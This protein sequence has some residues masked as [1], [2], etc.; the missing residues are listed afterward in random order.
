MAVGGLSHRLSIATIKSPTGP[1]LFST[2]NHAL[3]G[4]SE[5]KQT[6]RREEENSVCG[7]ETLR[8]VKLTSARPERTFAETL[9][10]WLKGGEWVLKTTA[11]PVLGPYINLPWLPAHQPPRQNEREIWRWAACHVVCP[12]PQS[13]LRLDLG[14]SRLWTKRWLG[15]LTSLIQL[16]E[17]EKR[18]RQVR[19]WC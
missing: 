19:V 7:A 18:E 11:N 10:H 3:V 12:S 14:S 16:L 1:R 4:S 9:S 6:T 15:P 5:H 2:R 17:T 13:S 8:R